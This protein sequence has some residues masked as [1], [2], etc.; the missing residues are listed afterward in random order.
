MSVINV[1]SAVFIVFSFAGMDRLVGRRGYVN[2][3]L[4]VLLAYAVRLRLLKRAEPG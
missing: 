1:S 4:V 3:T 2:G